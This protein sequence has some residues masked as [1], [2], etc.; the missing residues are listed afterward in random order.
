MARLMKNFTSLDKLLH[1]LLS[2][3]SLNL[4]PDGAVIQEEGYQWPAPF[5]ASHSSNCHHMSRKYLNSHRIP[6]CSQSTVA[7][8]FYKRPTSLEGFLTQSQSTIIRCQTLSFTS[9]QALYKHGVVFH[10]NV[11][12]SHA[13]SQK[14]FSKILFFRARLTIHKLAHFAALNS[15]K[16]ANYVAL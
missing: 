16:N 8:C 10:E 14:W 1:E 15:Q 11:H 12:E 2:P 3:V 7:T 9:C 6:Q 4:K 5:S 13:R